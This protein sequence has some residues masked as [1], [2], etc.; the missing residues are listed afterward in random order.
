MNTCEIIGKLTKQENVN[1]IERNKMANTFVV[2][3]ASPLAAYYTRFSQ[4]NKPKTV[5]FLTTNPVSFENILRATKKINMENNLNLEGAK[6]E[7]SF[8]RDKY[9][10]IRVKG[11]EQYSDIEAIQRLYQKEGFDFAKNGRMKRD[12][13]A[14]IRINKFFNL[15]REEEGVYHSPHNKDRYYFVIPKHVNWDEFRDLTKDVKNNVSVTGFD[16]AKGILY[17]K[18]G[19][20]EMVR[21]IRPDLTL[22]MVKEVRDKFLDRLS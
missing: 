18:D 19:I 14:M 6:C 22:E 7:I 2:H 11:I 20:T 5:L 16:V 1:P 4:I 10:G 3:I 21:I 17:E 13:N 9:S 8:G 12:T 15:I